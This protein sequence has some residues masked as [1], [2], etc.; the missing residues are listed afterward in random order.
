MAANVTQAAEKLAKIA[1]AIQRTISTLNSEK[2]IPPK[3]DKAQIRLL[4]V[5]WIVFNATTTTPLVKRR[6]IVDDS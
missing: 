2:G 6:M 3:S 1:V 4:A 5:I